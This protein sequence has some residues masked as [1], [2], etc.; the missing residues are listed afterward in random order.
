V[1][2]HEKR[3]RPKLYGISQCECSIPTSLVRFTAANTAPLYVCVPSCRQ[4]VVPS[5]PAS[6]FL[7]EMLVV[8]NIIHTAWSLV[9]T[10]AKRRAVRRFVDYFWEC[11]LY[12]ASNNIRSM[13]GKYTCLE[14]H[15]F[16]LRFLKLL[17]GSSPRPKPPF[18]FLLPASTLKS[19]S[20]GFTKTACNS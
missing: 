13:T 19:N 5:H 11:V 2:Y 17:N 14:L 7:V 4:R 3:R 9:Q 18:G 12:I 8:H 16:F 10:G 6:S 20:I 1:L 15:A